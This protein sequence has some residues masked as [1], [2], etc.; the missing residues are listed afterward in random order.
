MTSVRVSVTH[1]TGDIEVFVD[2]PTE[3]TAIHDIPAALGDALSKV[4]RAYNVES[5]GEK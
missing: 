5:T 4:V 1:H 3:S 2:H